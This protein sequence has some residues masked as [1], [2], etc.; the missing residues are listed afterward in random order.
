MIV[1]YMLSGSACRAAQIDAL[2]RVRENK[3]REPQKSCEKLLRQRLAARAGLPCW[4]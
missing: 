1:T 4:E 3:K 2:F